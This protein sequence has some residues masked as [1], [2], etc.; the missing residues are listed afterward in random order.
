MKKH[1]SIVSFHSY[2]G[3]L[4]PMQHWPSQER[5]ESDVQIKLKVRRVNIYVVLFKKCKS[6]V[7][8]SI[9][10][11]ASR[12]GVQRSTAIKARKC[13]SRPAFIASDF[14]SRVQSQDISRFGMK[15]QARRAAHQELHPEK[16]SSKQPSRNWK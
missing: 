1:Y 10:R 8:M 13:H 5:I 11:R 7:G 15:K 12:G 3:H 2:P 14:S 9:D 16:T 4:D 6:I